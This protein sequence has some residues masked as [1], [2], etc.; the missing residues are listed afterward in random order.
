[1]RK[2]VAARGRGQEQGWLDLDRLARAELTSEDPDHPLEGA[3]AGGGPG[4]WRAADGGEQTIRLLFDDPQRVRRI[5]L[6]FEELEQARTQ[7]FA[8]SAW[9]A[10]EAPRLLRRQQYTFG[11]PTT[12]AEVETCEV[13]LEGVVGLEL[14]IV[15]DIGGGPA[16]ASL[17][18]LRV[19]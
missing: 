14:V 5:R 11:P 10:G 2:T 6:E 3:L 8:L 19:A 16:R 7:E 18:L 17:A 1:M 13:D 9:A 15:P 12:T 4:G